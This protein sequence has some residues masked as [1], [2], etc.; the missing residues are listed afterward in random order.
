[1]KE[2]QIKLKTKIA[3]LGIIGAILAGSM[4]AET[5]V[6]NVFLLPTNDQSYHLGIA[7]NIVSNAP[8]GDVRWQNACQENILH[9]EKFLAAYRLPK[10]SMFR[11]KC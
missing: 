4:V 8:V 3:V 11:M 7:S 6:K 1:M 2:M 9:K 10:G 5:P